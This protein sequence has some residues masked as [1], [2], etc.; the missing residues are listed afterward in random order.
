MADT[1][2]LSLR[3]EL[4][5]FAVPGNLSRS[6]GDGRLECHAC[7]HRCSIGPGREG[8]CKVRYN[9][10]GTLF[11]PWGYV[12]SAQV[13]PVEKKPFF[14]LL[15]GS[16]ALSFGM[17]G[18]DYHCGYCQ[19]WL[20]S[21]A[22][23]DPSAI[24]APDPVSPEDLVRVA[25]D[26]Q[27][28]VITSTYNEPLITSEWAVGIFRVARRYKLVT[29]YVSNGNATPEVLDYLQPWVDAYK[30]DLKG[31]NDRHY[32]RLGG[33]LER[34]LDTIRALHERKFWLEIVTLVV[35][36]FNDSEAEL[37]DIAQFIASV[38]PEIPWHVTAF[39]PDYRMADVESTPVRSLLRAA[40]IGRG[41]GLHYVY[42][43]NLPGLVGS[44][45]DTFCPGCGGVVIARSGYR[46][47]ADRLKDGSCGSCGTRIPGIWKR[48]K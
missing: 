44:F 42:A 36:G 43:G 30:V 19:N 13:D 10:G 45:E 16:R 4:N 22:L 17:L 18:C 32:R 15:P 46:I 25:L 37:R 3:R 7:G 40:E 20:T 5:T 26:Y 34:V 23:R 6:L 47:L 14:H 27:A 24:S 9:D 2:I 35:P 33:V 28:G 41:S 8:I 1:E 29:S 31:F 21:Q 12:G 48:P 38:S 39:H 11:V